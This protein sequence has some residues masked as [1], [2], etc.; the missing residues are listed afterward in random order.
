MPEQEAAVM[1][2]ELSALGTAVLMWMLDHM[3]AGFLH[4]LCVTTGLG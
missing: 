3:R 4:G 2:L 1:T